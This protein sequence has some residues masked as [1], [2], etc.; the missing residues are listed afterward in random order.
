MKKKS[1][2]GN[3]K[4]RCDRNNL[5]LKQKWYFRRN[6]NFNDKNLIDIKIPTSFNTL[7]GFE[8]YEGIFWHF[9]VFN[10]KKEDLSKNK[11]FFLKFSGINYKAKIWLNDS[12]LGSHEGGFVPFSLKIDQKNLQEE[13]FLAIYINN[14]RERS[15]IPDY[16]FDW[17]NWG[18][19]YRDVSLLSLDKNRVEKVK[20]KTILKSRQ[21]ARINISYKIMGTFPISWEIVDQDYRKVLY[22][23][24]FTK[25]EDFGAFTLTI[26]NPYLWSPESPYLYHFRIFNS[27]KKSSD[28]LYETNFGIREIEIEGI[29]VFLNKKRIVC[30][31]VSLHEELLP[32]GRSIPYEKRMEDIKRMKSLGFNALRTAHYSHDEALLEI[33]DKLGILILEEIPVYWMC[34][35]KS[36]K[37]FKLAAKMIKT[38]IE[39]DF[40]HP[41]VIWWSVGNEVPIERWEC[42]RFMRRLMNWARRFDDTRIITYASNKMIC[43]L[44]KRHAD[45]A[46]INAYFGWYYG[47]TNMIS[48][49]LDIM[50]VPVF[51]KKP[52]FYTEF[53][54]GARYGFRSCLKNPIKF[55]EENQLYILENS[56]KIF[57]SKDYLA[58]WFIWI[59]RDFR[60]FLRQNEYQQ[61]FNRKG[62]VSEKNEP[63]LIYKRIPQII[64][65]K[66]SKKTPK[67]IGIIMWILL[68]PI[69]FIGTYLFIDGIVH[70]GESRR[71]RKGKLLDKKRIMNDN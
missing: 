51:N 36:N 47:G 57:N 6:F 34:D 41:S 70:L 43:D 64:N 15:Q 21:E 26:K 18:G 12:Y 25:G 42:A 38:L 32:F 52:W 33:A 69:A 46:A 9:L 48:K 35:Y 50:R 24:T 62:I 7:E 28:P 71:I 27:S 40:N 5:G 13:N 14:S 61:G 39:R 31:G 4:A 65:Q 59:Y 45:V 22:K 17:F 54:A 30:K 66:D 11:D 19:I 8:V 56:I 58:G 55:S 20:I 16:S 60:S 3:W 44:A 37:T 10:M 49:I 53:G 68:Y 63:K 23:G 1:L 67:I 29:Y 2:N